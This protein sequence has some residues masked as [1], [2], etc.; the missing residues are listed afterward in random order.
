[1]PPY[2][3]V[4]DME[5]SEDQ[6]QMAFWE[7]VRQ[8]LKAHLDTRNGEGRV[9]QAMLARMLGLHPTTLANFLSSTNHSLGGFAMARACALG[10]QFECDQQRIG[11]IE[12]HAERS[13]TASPEQLVLEF[14][15]DF[16]IVREAEPLTIQLKRPPGKAPSSADISLKF[17]SWSA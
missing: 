10:I 12:R 17:A 8:A 3:I 2:D 14:S 7:R 5:E 15:D 6:A 1:M 11:R 9:T 4:Y 16:R 13:S